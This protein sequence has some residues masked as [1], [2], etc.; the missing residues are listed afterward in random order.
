M[1]RVSTRGIVTPTSGEGVKVVTDLAAMADSIEDDIGLG[2]YFYR[3]TA[4]E[5]AAAT[6]SIKSG[7]HWQDTDSPNMEWRKVGG[8]TGHWQSVTV[9]SSGPTAVRLALEDPPKNMIWMDTT[10]TKDEWVYGASGWELYPRITNAV[11]TATHETVFTVAANWEV[12]GFRSR[13]RGG[14][15]QINIDALYSGPDI[16]PTTPD[17][18]ID[19][20]RIGTMLDPYIPSFATGGSSSHTGRLAAAYI[21]DAGGMILT[22]LT[23][24]EPLTAGERLTFTFTILRG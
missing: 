15:A 9:V 4:A 14:V 24:S 13:I 10:G 11:N 20:V 8:A 5:R 3:G 7:A 22:A 18:N 6:P 21:S 1:P 17:G 19:N 12:L 2:A 23:N 16:F